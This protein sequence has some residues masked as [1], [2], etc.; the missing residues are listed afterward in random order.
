MADASE[1]M[2]E[3]V[4]RFFAE[5]WNNHDIDSLMSFMTDE[6]VFTASAGPFIYGTRYT[7]IEEVRAGFSEVFATFPD[8]HWSGGHHFICGN[9]GVSEW[10]FTGTSA[11]GTRLEVSGCDIF[12]FRGNKI[13]FKNS[14]RKNR[15]S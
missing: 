6:C 10:T 14:F 15:T 8:A 3:D 9:R 4:L 11:D 1:K 5:S 2:R 7:G 12:T 13:A